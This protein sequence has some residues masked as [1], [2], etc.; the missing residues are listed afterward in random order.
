MKGRNL[1]TKDI[2]DQRLDPS[3]VTPGTNRTGSWCD[4][5]KV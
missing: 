1:S 3:A 2:S 4:P 5:E